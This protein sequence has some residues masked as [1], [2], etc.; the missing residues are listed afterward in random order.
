MDCCDHMLASFRGCF[1]FLMK[2]SADSPTYVWN[3][4]LKD[5][6]PQPPLAA[7]TFLALSSTLFLPRLYSSTCFPLSGVPAAVTHTLPHSAP[8][9]LAAL[10]VS[11]VQH[12]RRSI[13]QCLLVALP[14]HRSVARSSQ[15]WCPAHRRLTATEAPTHAMN[16]S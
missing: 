7:S 16:H 15:F 1:F 8:P 10:H 11:A 13:I 2:H 3:Q 9:L 5:A 14:L 6:D 12:G 4:C